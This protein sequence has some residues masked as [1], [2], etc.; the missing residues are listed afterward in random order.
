MKRIIPGSQVLELG[1][2]TGYMTRYLKEELGCTVTCV[3]IDANAAAKGSIYSA[4]MIVADLDL[5]EWY[6]Q[7]RGKGFDHVIFADVIEHLKDP[8]QVVRAAVQLLSPQGT[9]LISVPNIGHSSILME[10]LEG[11]FDYRPT[12]LLDDTHIRFFTRKSLLDLLGRAGMC[13]IELMGTT[14]EPEDTEFGQSYGSLAVPLQRLLKEREDAHIY[15]YVV[16]AKRQEEVAVDEYRQPLTIENSSTGKDFLQVYWSD[17][18]LSE[19][20]SV[21]VPLRDQQEFAKYEIVLPE[22]VGESGVLRLDPT[23]F[24]AF[25]EIKEIEL[26]TRDK[27]G[28]GQLVS[29]WSAETGFT[30]LEISQGTIRM[31]DETSL[32]LLCPNDDPQVTLTALPSIKE[33]SLLCLKMRVSRDLQQAALAEVSAQRANIIDLRQSLENR[34]AAIKELKATLERSQKELGSRVADIDGLKAAFNRSQEERDSQVTVIDEL[35]STIE[36][37]QEELKQRRAEVADYEQQLKEIK[38]STVWRAISKWMRMTCWTR[39]QFKLG[40]DLLQGGYKQRLI[41]LDNIIPLPAKGPGYWQAVGEDPKFLL[42]GPFPHGWSEIRFKAASPFPLKV[43]IYFDRGRGFNET[44]SLA[45]EVVCGES[46][47]DYHVIVLVGYDIKQVRLDPGET[48]GKFAINSCRIARVTRIG[49]ILRAF[50]L[51][52]QRQ[53]YSWHSM[54][55]WTRQIGSAIKRGGP[56]GL[57]RWAKNLIAPQEDY[58]LWLKYHSLTE[59]RKKMLQTQC[60]ELAFKPV[61][62]ILVPVYNV[63]ERWL[64]SC[65]DSVREQVYPHWELCIADDASTDPQ[66]QKMLKEYAARDPRIK[67]IYR[68]KNGHIS[69]ASNSALELATGEYIGLLD[70]DDCLTADA[71]CENALLINQH[72]EAVMIYSDEDKIGEDGVRHSP[73]FKPDWSPDNLLAQMYTCHF[74][75]YKTSVVRELGGFRLGFEGSQDHDLALRVSETTDEIYHIAKVLYHWRTVAESTAVNVGAKS[76]ATTA[77][78]KAV[79]EAL[80][81]R[82]EGG[83]VEALERYPYYRAH[84]PVKGNPLISI[85]IPT[86]DMARLLGKCLETI[87]SKT[88]Y[89][90]Y[91]VLIIDNGSVKSET[92]Q[93][94]AK[95][96]QLEP[97]RFRVIH[98]DIPFNYS[99]LNNQAVQQA[100]GELVVLLNNDVEIITPNWLEEMAGQAM[101]PSIGAV[102]AKL[103]YPDQTIQHAGV[104][105]GIGGVGGHSHRGRGSEEPGYFGRLIIAANYAAV[106]GACLMVKKELFCQ[107]GGLEEKLTVAFNDVDFCLKLWEKG[108]YNLVLPQVKLYHFESKSRGYE[109]TPE[110]MQRFLGEVNY[111]KQHWKNFLERDPFYNPNLTLDRED[112]SLA[113]PG[114]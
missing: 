24:P 60:A 17:K 11:R 36:S 12:G 112:F 102:G 15:Q 109:D 40:R 97:Q 5:M 72:P 113:M 98:L 18:G 16:V 82:G 22:S 90:H 67:V 3:E 114:E 37:N 75:V 49:I 8:W 48:E 31:S 70:H 35:K 2:A 26:N 79:G 58:D 73:F 25:V 42:S 78:L 64:R 29:Q 99:R 28:P 20:K 10:L 33:Q 68:E 74:G 105:L 80:Q 4:K 52:F 66:V 45:L 21:T 83:W 92:Q 85:I 95:W 39:E 53:G 57:W 94:F 61:F 13:P 14:T 51:F 30:N 103:L 91:E 34:Q 89:P 100:K 1:S 104:T 59:A 19:S 43:R 76:Y 38:S 63:D 111:M 96:Q 23:N 87:F 110:K 56:K 44:E 41:P 107:V 81:R 65:L 77:G 32:K 101:R 93:L 27:Q 86:R 62:S 7:L 108:Y 71:L 50:G 47:Q 88:R 69:A 46:I 6:E 55:L 9:L 54:K 106:T 84:Y